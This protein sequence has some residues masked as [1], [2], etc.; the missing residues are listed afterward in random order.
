MYFKMYLFQIVFVRL[1]VGWCSRGGLWAFL[2]TAFVVGFER[3][4]LRRETPLAI[5]GGPA[6]D[7]ERGELRNT[8]MPKHPTAEL[9]VLG[10]FRRLQGVVREELQ[11]GQGTHSHRHGPLAGLG[12]GGEAEVTA[13]PVAGPQARA[14]S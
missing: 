10:D 8:F 9:K 7:W 11:D 1:P 4:G 6:C 14:P 2:S 12:R 5:A 13:D 3:E